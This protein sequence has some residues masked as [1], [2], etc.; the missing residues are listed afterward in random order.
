MPKL[1]FGLVSITLNLAGQTA[2]LPTANDRSLWGEKAFG[3][4]R[5]KAAAIVRI[6]W[7]FLLASIT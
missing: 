3:N 4:R 7:Q 6:K 5:R 2:R 1:L